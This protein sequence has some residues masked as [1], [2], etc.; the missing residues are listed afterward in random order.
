[1]EE[2]GPIC[3]QCHKPVE[4]VVERSSP[5]SLKYRLLDHGAKFGFCKCPMEAS[6]P[7]EGNA[8]PDV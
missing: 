3:P 1:M 6:L 7:A 5:T 4:E 2:R 8:E